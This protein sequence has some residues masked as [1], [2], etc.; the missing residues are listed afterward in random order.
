MREDG[1]YVLDSM[2]F[3]DD[4]ILE[5]EFLERR[6]LD[7]A[8]LVTCNADFEVL[9]DESVRD[10]CCALVFCTGEED[11][12]EVRGPLFELTRPILEGCFWDDD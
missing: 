3:I 5:T 6:F 12:V 9:R 11:N 1:I 4:N 8:D 10:D 2:G 7:E